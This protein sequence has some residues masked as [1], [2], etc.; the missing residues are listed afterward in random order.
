MRK[1]KWVIAVE[2][3]LSIVFGVIF[4]FFGLLLLILGILPYLSGGVAR[5][6]GMEYSM[7]LIGGPW[8]S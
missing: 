2:I 7:M 1:P 3:A 6:A 4:L 5:P 8:H